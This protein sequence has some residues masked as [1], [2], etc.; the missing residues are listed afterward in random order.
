MS[1][2]RKWAVFVDGSSVSAKAFDAAC[3]FLSS[4]NSKGG[5]DQLT[6]VHAHDPEIDKAKACHLRGPFIVSSYETNLI[7]ARRVYEGMCS[8]RLKTRVVSKEFKK[9]SESVEVC[10]QDLTRSVTNVEN[11]PPLVAALLRC[12]AE[13]IGSDYIFLGS[14]G[15]GGTKVGQY[16]TVT[17][18]LVRLTNATTFVV[19]HWRPLPKAGEGACLVVAIDGEETSL[20]AVEEILQ[21]STPADRVIGLLVSRHKGP[22]DEAVIKRVDEIVAKHRGEAVPECLCQW[23]EL[24]EGKGPASQVICDTAEKLEADFLVVGS[25]NLSQGSRSRESMPLMG[26]TA[27]YCSHHAKCHVIVVKPTSAA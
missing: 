16:G 10:H 25:A 11:A 20:R 18:Y 26:S 9:S 14:F 7:K 21:I 22:R 13:E 19:N 6:V 15:E 1:T 2:V 17:D 12:N 27:L 3:F 4:Q 23:A 8:R 5:T 24:T